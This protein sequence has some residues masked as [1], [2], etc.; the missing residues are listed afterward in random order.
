[1][2]APR[3]AASFI[4]AKFPSPRRGRFFGTVKDLTSKLATGNGGGRRRV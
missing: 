2:N 3:P 4:S 1:M